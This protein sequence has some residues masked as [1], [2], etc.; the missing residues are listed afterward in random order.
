MS[1]RTGPA[2]GRARRHSAFFAAHQTGDDFVAV[3]IDVL[4]KGNLAGRRFLDQLFLNGAEEFG[5]LLR[6]EMREPICER[7]VIARLDERPHDK[8]PPWDRPP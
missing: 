7:E 1:H 3:E 6:I 2:Q 8:N 5:R 4:A